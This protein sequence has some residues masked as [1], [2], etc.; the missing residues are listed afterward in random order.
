LLNRLTDDD[1]VTTF[2]TVELGVLGPLQ[3][4]QYGAPVTIPGAKPC[5]ILT[6][7]GLHGGSVVSAHTPSHGVTPEGFAAEWRLIELLTVAGDRINRCELFNES[8]DDAA[9]A[10]FDELTRGRPGWQPVDMQP[11]GCL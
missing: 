1:D 8:D 4:R 5:A 7:L 10:R 9:I 11:N 6:M 2:Q 3:V